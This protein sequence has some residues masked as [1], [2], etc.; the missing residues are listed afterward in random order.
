VLSPGLPTM[1]HQNCHIFCC[2][3]ADCNQAALDGTSDVA[4]DG[5]SSNDVCPNRNGNGAGPGRGISSSNFTTINLAADLASMADA[6][7]MLSGVNWYLFVVVFALLVSWATVRIGHPQI[8]N[9]LKWRGVLFA[10][11][12]NDVR[13][14]G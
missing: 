10:F 2:G 9:V 13:G 12:T 7:E 6:A 1:T 4:A 14:G 3:R 8:A 11:P 5:R